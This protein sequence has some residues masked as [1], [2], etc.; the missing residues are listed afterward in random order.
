M[1]GKERSDGSHSQGTEYRIGGTLFRVD[2]AEL[3]G[4]EGD[5]DE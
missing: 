2:G 3:S 1:E 4:M 5:V